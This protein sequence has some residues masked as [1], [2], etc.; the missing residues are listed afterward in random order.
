MS[1]QLIYFFILGTVLVITGCAEGDESESCFSLEEAFFSGDKNNCQFVE[2]YNSVKTNSSC[3]R[4]ILDSLKI[5]NISIDDEEVVKNLYL[6]GKVA[7][8][9]GKNIN[10]ILEN[11]ESMWGY[12]NGS[13][14]CETVLSKLLVR[15]DYFFKEQDVRLYFITDSL[16][17]QTISNDLESY[18]TLLEPSDLNTGENVRSTQLIQVFDAFIDEVASGELSILVTDALYSRGFDLN[19]TEYINQ[20]MSILEGKFLSLLSRQDASLYIAKFQSNFRGKYFSIDPLTGREKRNYVGGERTFQRPFYL[21]IAGNSTELLNYLKSMSLKDYS[22]FSNGYLLNFPMEIT[23]VCYQLNNMQTV[24]SSRLDRDNV[25]Y[26]LTDVEP[27]QK[28]K[29]GKLFSYQITADLDQYPVPEEYL[30]DVNNYSIYPN[31]YNLEIEK[32]AEDERREY[33]INYP[34]THVFTI[35]TKEKP[36]NESI[37]ISLERKP[38]KIPEW[39]INTNTSADHIL[40]SSSQRHTRGFLPL[41]QSMQQAYNLAAKKEFGSNSSYFSFQ[42]EISIQ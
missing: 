32:L 11:S 26:N 2:F 28:S 22:G 34:Y 40:D 15:T 3:F 5:D 31:R 23:S 24:G 20:V 14:I 13:T 10:Y 12:F 39:V 30:M 33:G 4:S 25:L 35:Y 16:R 6:Y 27:A 29:D 36:Q 42:T 8:I 1:R 9:K 18:V 41:I 17:E 7:T 19:E 21:F 37:K 38:F